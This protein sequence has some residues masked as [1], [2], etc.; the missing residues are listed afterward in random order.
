[1]MDSIYVGMS[2]L[3]AASRGLSN[4]SNN[5]ANLNTAGYK[6]FELVY[7]DVGYR[8]DT[9]DL[10]N[11]DNPSQTLG[12]GVAPG[13]AVQVFQQGEFRQTG[14]DLDAAVDGVGLFVVRRDGVT[15]L[16]R[17]GQFVFNSD[18]VLTT[19]EDNA[20]VAGLNN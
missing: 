3:L 20:H 19:R 9:G 16:T 4:I 5:V 7:K 13:P 14:N 2:G 11:S 12:A 17:A 1:M 18:G 15:Y 10:G 6:R 8:A